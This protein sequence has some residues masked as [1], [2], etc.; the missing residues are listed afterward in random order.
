[1]IKFV[2]NAFDEEADIESMDLEALKD[3]MAQL[4][5]QIALL[6]EKEP[7]NMNSEAYEAWGDRHELLED[8][9]DDVLDRLEELE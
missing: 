8:L 6:D 5:E 3:Y 7:R 4:Q 2:P 1:M 9:L